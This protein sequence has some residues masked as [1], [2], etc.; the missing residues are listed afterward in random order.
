MEATIARTPGDMKVRLLR[1]RIVILAAGVG[2]RLGSP[3]PK[4]LTVLDD[5]RSIMERQ[6]SSLLSVFDRCTITTVIGF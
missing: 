3:V 4:P 5:G 1:M 2:S 6:V